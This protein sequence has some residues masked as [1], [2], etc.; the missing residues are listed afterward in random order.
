MTLK[1]STLAVGLVFG[2][3]VYLAINSHVDVTS[4]Y[5]AF[6][7]RSLM[8]HPVTANSASDIVSNPA[9]INAIDQMITSVGKP[10]T[11]LKI[12]Q[13]INQS[14]SQSFPP[15]PLGDCIIHGIYSSPNVFLSTRVNED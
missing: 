15:D 3:M 7:S 9:V 12:N 2:F 4:N 14:N 6:S 1:K 13:S 5:P 11:S 10:S 8:N